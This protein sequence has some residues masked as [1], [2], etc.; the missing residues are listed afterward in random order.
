MKHDDLRLLLR[1]VLMKLQEGLD[2]ETD[3]DVGYALDESR[4]MIEEILK[5][6]DS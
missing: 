6:L 2:A 5:A 4:V 3:D 1:I